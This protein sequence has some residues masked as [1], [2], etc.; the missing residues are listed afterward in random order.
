MVTISFIL[1]VAMGIS[2]YSLDVY[3]D[4]NF[5]INMNHQANKNFTADFN[6]CFNKFNGEFDELIQTCKGRVKKVGKNIFLFDVWSLKGFLCKEIFFI[7][8]FFGNDKNFHTLTSCSWDTQR[9]SINI[10]VKKCHK[11]VKYG[12]LSL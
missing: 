7:P 12:N 8:F 6:A 9:L 10:F 11:S 4:I 5:A 3:T 2:F 1:Q